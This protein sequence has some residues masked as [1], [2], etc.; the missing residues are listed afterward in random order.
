MNFA[1]LASGNGSNLQAI[2]DALKKGRIKGRL[3]T[4]ISD[5]QEAFA[6]TRARKAG[7]KTVLAIDPQD[8]ASR[9]AFDAALVKALKKDKV[10]L[11]VLAGFMRILSPVFVKAFRNRI[12]NI[13]PAI[14]P[15]F[16]GAHAVKDALTYGVKVTGVTVHLVDEEVDHGAIIAQV[17]VEVLVRDTE[18]SLAG[19]IHQAEHVIYPK[20]IDLF[21]RGRIKV[22]GRMVRVG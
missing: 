21:L 7:V 6:L 9:G 2:L 3:T 8:F 20:V 13:H 11:I 16:K 19:R 22:S 1:V 15:S 17:P 5:R 10:G 12:I 18:A 4:V 14:L